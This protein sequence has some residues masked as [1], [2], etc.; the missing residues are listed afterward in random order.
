MRLASVLF[1]AGWAPAVHATELFPAPERSDSYGYQTATVDLLS[2]TLA[3]ASPKLGAPAGISAFGSYLV[4]APLVHA[5]HGRGTASA[6][7]LGMRL[8]AASAGAS[9]GYA[10]GCG[11]GE[12]NF[13]TRGVMDGVIGA[14]VGLGVGAIGASVV[15]AIW[16]ARKPRKEATLVPSFSVV[17]ASTT[18][19]L[20]GSF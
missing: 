6:F 10:V 19:G 2:A 5:I 13:H 7:D 18:W 1:V 8:V 14:S 11:I 9:L 17:G 16:L 12:C 20:A 15:D 3:L 4:L